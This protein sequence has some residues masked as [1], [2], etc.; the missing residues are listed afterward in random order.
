MQDY[1]RRFLIAGI[2]A[3]CVA[4]L[5]L[6]V[7]NVQAESPPIHDL[8][9]EWVWP[10]EGVLTDSFGTRN[11]VHKGID[12]AAP[13]GS[14]V[15]AVDKGIVTK[16]Y[17]SDTYGNVVFV[18]HEYGIET[19][20]AHLQ[21][22]TVQEGVKVTKGEIIGKMGNTGDSSGVHLHFEVHKQEWTFDKK[23]AVNPLT[24]L[25]YVEVGQAVTAA[26]REQLKVVETSAQPHAGDG[27]T[28]SASG[29][30]STDEKQNTEISANIISHIVRSGETLWSIAE[31]HQTTVNAIQQQNGLQ[32]G[33]ISAG[34]KL[35]IPLIGQTYIVQQG[36]TLIAIAR[37]FK[38]SVSELKEINHMKNSL[39]RPGEKLRLTN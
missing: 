38:V 23:N 14:P 21:E 18:K 3:V 26:G 17:Y 36:D 25:G 32:S 37:K 15:Y 29:A 10:S 31:E 5:F 4:L 30:V 35:L 11:G 2:M 28:A 27:Q 8:T 24:A 7:K 39:I 13:V 1:L 19:V 6:G 12:I 22:R 16:S 33:H 20:Y 34:Q 9:S